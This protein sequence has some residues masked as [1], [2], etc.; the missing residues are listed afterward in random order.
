MNRRNF[1]AILSAG[2]VV[3]GTANAQKKSQ[4]NFLIIYCDD[5]VTE[6]I[7]HGALVPNIDSMKKAGLFFP[8]AYA[9]APACTPAR[10]N[11]LTGQYAGRCKGR[12]PQTGITK[13]GQTWVHWNADTSSDDWTGAKVLRD[14]GYATGIVGKVGCFNIQEAKE[15]KKFMTLDVDDPKKK[16]MFEEYQRIMSEG[17]KPF[18]FDYGGALTTSNMSGNDPRHA[19]EYQLE[20]CLEFIGKNRKTPFYLHF[21][22]HLMHMPNPGTS[23]KGDPRNVYG[24]MMDEAPAVQPSRES[25]LERVKAAG[26][27]EELAPATWLDDTIGVLFQ[28]LEKWGL[29]EN[30]LVVFMQDNGHHG[31]KG[32][33]YEGGAD[34]LGCWMRWPKAIKPGSANPTPMMNIDIVPTMLAAAGVEPPKAYKPDG[35]SLLPAFDGSGK[36]LR[37]SVMIEIGHT[38]AVVKDN[39]KYIALRVPESH[40]L[41]P[42][43]KAKYKELA[44]I[45]PTMDPEGRVTH[46]HRQLGGCSTERTE[47]MA[48]KP[49]FYDPDQLYDL[50]KDPDEQNNL[51]GH[52]EYGAKLKSMQS[53]MRQHMLKAPGTFGE[54]KGFDDLPPAERAYIEKAGANT[55]WKEPPVNTKAL[56]KAKKQGGNKKKKQ[57][58]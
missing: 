45:D 30:T 9:A 29:A 52:P 11:A 40:Q 23:L 43:L 53:L 58:S 6:S 48:C 22:P 34:V 12:F 37:D 14:A 31:G 47:A 41:S 32:S 33:C 44:K 8:K 46:I 35:M 54:F 21:V 17:V 16:P 42:E 3:A 25:V 55:K 18:G 5:H 4:P 2:I 10:Y 50:S 26:L 28:S 51:A 20:H 7:Q 49:G 38:R 27:D 24:V 39:W 15:T 1:N 13:E 36:K 19:P 57:G 56:Q